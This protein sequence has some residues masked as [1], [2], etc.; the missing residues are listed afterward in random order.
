ME[1]KLTPLTQSNILNGKEFFE[2]RFASLPEVPFE[3][4]WF[5]L[6]RYKFPYIH[7]SKPIEAQV[8]TVNPENQDKWILTQTRYGAWP[9]V[10]RDKDPERIVSIFITEV[11]ARVP[12]CLSRVLEEYNT[13]VKILGNPHV[14]NIGKLIEIIGWELSSLPRSVG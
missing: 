12:S 9:F 6:G 5:M 13:P 3:P 14:P 8:R 10:M 2:E 11:P 4:L 1:N 7:I